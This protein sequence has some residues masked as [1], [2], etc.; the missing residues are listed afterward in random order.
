[1]IYIVPNR[2]ICYNYGMMEEV[3]IYASKQSATESSCEIYESK[4][5]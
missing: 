2:H 4:L 1:M 5:R 3:R